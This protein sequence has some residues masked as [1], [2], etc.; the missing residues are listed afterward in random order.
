[1]KYLLNLKQMQPLCPRH[2]LLKKIPKGKKVLMKKIA[3]II[4]AARPIP[5]LN[6]CG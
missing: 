6:N 1:M 3:R 4:W 2:P 5:S